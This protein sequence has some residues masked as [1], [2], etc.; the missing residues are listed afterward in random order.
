MAV[1]KYKT[2]L[3]EPRVGLCSNWLASIN[4]S[5]NESAAAEE[6]SLVVHH[7]KRESSTNEDSLVRNSGNEDSLLSRTRDSEVTPRVPIWVQKG[8]LRFPDDDKPCI[9]IGP[10]QQSLSIL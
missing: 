10:G 5:I 2:K 1:V 9:L 4:P 7:G 3:R 6:D 8:S